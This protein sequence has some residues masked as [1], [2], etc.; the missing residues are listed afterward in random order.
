M[1]EKANVKDKKKATTVCI[2]L[3]AFKAYER[4][5][6]HK[7]VCF[8]VGASR[9]LNVRLDTL[10]G[11]LFVLLYKKEDTKFACS[12]VTVLCRMDE[13]IGSKRRIRKL[14]KGYWKVT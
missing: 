10:T 3:A 12:P 2:I 4:A 9:G 5:L 13:G 11:G 14:V 7:H 8:G 1:A 6:E